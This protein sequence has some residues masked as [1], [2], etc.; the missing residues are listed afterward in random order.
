MTF[1]VGW[2]SRP[3]RRG[4]VGLELGLWFGSG[5]GLGLA[6]WVCHM[7]MFTPPEVTLVF[8][9]SLPLCTLL[10]ALCV[11]GISP[12]SQITPSIHI[13]AQVRENMPS[14][15]FRFWGVDNATRHWHSSAAGAQWPRI[16]IAAGTVVWDCVRDGLSKVSK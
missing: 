8:S 3:S 4:Y 15:Q 7:M 14:F 16:V 11:Q 2:E 1:L 5:L 12:Q 10:S 13:G 9:S 6:L